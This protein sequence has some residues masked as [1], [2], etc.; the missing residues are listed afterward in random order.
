MFKRLFELWLR[1]DLL[2][3]ALKNASEMLIMARE[4]YLCSTDPLFRGKT[5]K[6]NDIYSMDRDINEFEIK[7]RQKVLE[8]LSISPRQNTSESYI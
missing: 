8:H 4:L 6:C 7:I 5:G 1:E 3:Q 2:Q